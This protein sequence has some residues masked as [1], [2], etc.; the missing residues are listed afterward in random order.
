MQC[1]L[2]VLR[3]ERLPPQ[4]VCAYDK[5]RHANIPGP[6]RIAS[7]TR[8]CTSAPIIPP[9]KPGT[10]PL[11]RGFFAICVQPDAAGSSR[12]E[13]FACAIQRQQRLKHAAGQASSGPPV[14]LHMHPSIKMQR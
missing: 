12:H 7:G 11:L 5:A 2:L 14:F 9:A 1:N 4:H 6:V 3:S 13:L 8:Q 10:Q